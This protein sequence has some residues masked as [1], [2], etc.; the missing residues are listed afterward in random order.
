MT[1]SPCSGVEISKAD[2]LLRSRMLDELW[3]AKLAKASWCFRTTEDDA[4]HGVKVCS[5]SSFSACM[6]NGRCSDTS[7]VLVSKGLLLISHGHLQQ[8]T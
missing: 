4:V 5:R 2:F 3:A 1:Q 7:T 8:P 6:R